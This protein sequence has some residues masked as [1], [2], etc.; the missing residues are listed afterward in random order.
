MRNIKLLFSSLTVA[1]AI[2]GL[3]RAVSYDI[4]MPIV[5]ICMAISIF[6]TA[7]E[8]K[9]GGKKR[10]ALWFLLLGIFLLIITVYNIV[11][12]VWGI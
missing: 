11:S 2:L 5:F 1:F 6:I 7:K 10:D 3:T 4:T 9:D 12:T 8:Y